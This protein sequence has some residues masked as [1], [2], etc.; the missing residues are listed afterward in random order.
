MYLRPE[1]TAQNLGGHIRGGIYPCKY[2]VC[3]D[4]HQRALPVVT[5]ALHDLAREETAGALE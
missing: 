5:T 2:G 4:V 1:T 3:T